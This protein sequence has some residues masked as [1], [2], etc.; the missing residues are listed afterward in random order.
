MRLGFD[1]LIV[2]EK[3]VEVILE[4]KQTSSVRTVVA[5]QSSALDAQQGGERIKDVTDRAGSHHE[6]GLKLISNHDRTDFKKPSPQLTT[7]LNWSDALREDHTNAT[8]SLPEQI[9]GE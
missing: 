7:G 3:S 6:V 2:L 4:R 5:A 9:A 8:D 1:A